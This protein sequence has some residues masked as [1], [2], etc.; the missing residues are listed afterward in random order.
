MLVQTLYLKYQ[1]RKNPFG[2]D[3]KKRVL[4]L[5]FINPV[6]DAKIEELIKKS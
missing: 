1:K 2:K 3:L 4:N 6:K 5:F